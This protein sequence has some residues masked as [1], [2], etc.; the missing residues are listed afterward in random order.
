[1]KD[2]GLF[3]EKIH[4]CPNNCIL[5]WDGREHQEECDKCH[6]FR[7]K[8]KTRNC[9]KVLRYFPLMLRLL[10]MYKSSR[11]AEDMLW[12]YR[13]RVKDGILRHPADAKACKNFDEQNLHFASEARNVRLGLSSDGFNPFRVMSTTHSKHVLLNN[14]PLWLCLKQPLII[15]CMIIPREKAP[16]MDIDVYLQPLIKKLS[17]LWNG[18][19]AF[20]AHTKT[21]CK[22]HGLLYSTSEFPA[23]ANSS[24]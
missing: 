15:L 4:S 6:I 22:M 8:N 1:M 18:V 5:Y 14:L 19:D 11:I 16:G 21:N 12:H 13:D 3:Y 17:Q 9:Q 7:W 2:L 20:D 10:R 23:Y 24:G